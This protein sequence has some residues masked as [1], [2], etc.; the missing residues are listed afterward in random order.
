MKGAR[1]LTLGVNALAVLILASAGAA[2]ANT[3]T[4]DSLTVYGPQFFSGVQTVLAFL[5]SFSALTSS[6]LHQV[7]GY[8]FLYG[9]IDLPSSDYAFVSL[10]SGLFALTQT[11]VSDIAGGAL[12]G[13][14]SL[15]SGQSPSADQLNYIVLLGS[16]PLPSAASLMVSGIAALAY[17][18][19]VAKRKLSRRTAQPAAA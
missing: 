14:F 16:T 4:I 19:R 12:A 5:P 3:L 2:S 18:A 8:S 11:A 6:G 1:F 17:V 7:A 15:P 13:L 9:T 10:V